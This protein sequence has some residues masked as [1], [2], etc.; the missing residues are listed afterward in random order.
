MVIVIKDEDVA[1]AE[2]TL[3]DDAT[4]EDVVAELTN[5]VAARAMVRAFEEGE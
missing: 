2:V 5:A 4:F 3:P 1:L